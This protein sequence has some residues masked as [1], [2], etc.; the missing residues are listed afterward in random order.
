MV[1]DCNIYEGKLSH[2]RTKKRFVAEF[3]AQKLVLDKVRG[4]RAI[5]PV[6]V[7]TY[8]LTRN[9]YSSKIQKVITMDDLFQ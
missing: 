2:E 5:H 7:T 3:S 9:E 1:L 8:G 4:R 6:I